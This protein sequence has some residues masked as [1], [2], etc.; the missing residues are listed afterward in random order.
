MDI[1]V[2]PSG[3]NKKKKTISVSSYQIFNTIIIPVNRLEHNH[4][5]LSDE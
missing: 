5:G 1:R 3:G 2:S 4:S